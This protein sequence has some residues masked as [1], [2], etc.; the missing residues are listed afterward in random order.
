VAGQSEPLGG[1]VGCAV[2]TNRVGGGRPI[3]GRTALCEICGHH[4][5]TLNGPPGRPG[6]DQCRRDTLITARS[7]SGRP[8]G[9]SLGGWLCRPRPPGRRSANAPS[10][11]ARRRWRRSLAEPRL[12]ASVTTKLI[13][14]ARLA[15]SPRRDHYSVAAPC[16]SFR[17][18]SRARPRSA[19]GKAKWTLSSNP[20]REIYAP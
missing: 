12:G 1:H 11:P 18:C 17:S 3:T 20:C 5:R 8:D 7:G 6:R 9:A 2:L 15:R 4:R 14:T 16:R 13:H 10:S 19:V